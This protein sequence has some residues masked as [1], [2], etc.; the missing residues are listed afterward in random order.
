MGGSNHIND[1]TH[2][3]KLSKENACERDIQRRPN[4]V[5]TIS[6]GESRE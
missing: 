6:D 2:Y 1:Q 3:L 4:D 5:I